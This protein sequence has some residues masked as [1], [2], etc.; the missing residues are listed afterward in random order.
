LAGTKGSPT[1]S[2]KLMK[3]ILL[4]VAALGLAASIAGLGTYATFTSST[5]A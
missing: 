1:M 5:S 2:T 3:R 4:S